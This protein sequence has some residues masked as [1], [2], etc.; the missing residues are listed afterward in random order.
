[1]IGL[2]ASSGPGWVGALRNSLHEFSPAFQGWDRI[3][4][5]APA[6]RQRPN[7]RMLRISVRRSATEMTSLPRPG[8]QKAGL[9]SDRRYASNSRPINF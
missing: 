2:E 5:Y 6:S 1:M 7:E 3:E 9:N 8:L 4:I